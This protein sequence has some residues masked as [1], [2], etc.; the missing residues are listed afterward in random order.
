VLA[1]HGV[2]FPRIDRTWAVD[3]VK[4][5]VDWATKLLATSQGGSADG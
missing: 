4:R 1:L 5:T 2:E 3:A